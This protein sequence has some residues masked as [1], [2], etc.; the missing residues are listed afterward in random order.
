MG[1]A[2]VIDS[3]I[4]DGLRCAACDAHMGVT[5]EDRTT[6]GDRDAFGLQSQQRGGRVVVDRDEHPR[7]EATLGGLARLRPRFASDGTVTARSSSGINDGAAATVVMSAEAAR[8]DGVR[9]V[10]TIRGYASLRFGLS[11]LCIDV[12]QGIAMVVERSPEA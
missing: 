8:E 5:P 2:Q 10:A 3:T 4:H 1:D 12:G 9:P 7:P 6:R 11:A